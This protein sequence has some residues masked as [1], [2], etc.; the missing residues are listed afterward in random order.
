VDLWFAYGPAKN[1]AIY[2]LLRFSSKT[3]KGLIYERKLEKRCG[4][5]IFYVTFVVYH[6]EVE[7]RRFVHKQRIGHNRFDELYYGK[8]IIIKYYANHPGWSALAGEDADIR[9]AIDSTYLGLAN[10]VLITYILHYF[11]AFI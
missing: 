10:I 6:Y 1:W 3:T 4:K 9:G 7:N 2:I 11:G 5:G 8:P